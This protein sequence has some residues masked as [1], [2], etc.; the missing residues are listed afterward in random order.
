MP[1]N[2]SGGRISVGHYE[3][4][5]GPEGQAGSMTFTA[6]SN[7]LESLRFMTLK[8]T[9]WPRGISDVTL[10]KNKRRFERP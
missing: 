9:Q 10:N 6:S 1:V 4:E 7:R 8:Y 5:G 2:R 3:D